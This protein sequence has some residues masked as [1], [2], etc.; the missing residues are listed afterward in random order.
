MTEHTNYQTISAPRNYLVIILKA[1]ITNNHNSRVTNILGGRR[2]ALPAPVHITRRDI[3]RESGFFSPMPATMLCTACVR[4]WGVSEYFSSFHFYKISFCNRRN[5]PAYC[6]FGLV[7]E[8]T[9]S[10]SI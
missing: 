8:E 2:A 6:A 1:D 7:G 10:F 3:R 4:V 9:D 5:T